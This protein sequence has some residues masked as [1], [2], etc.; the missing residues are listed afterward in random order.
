MVREPGAPFLPYRYVGAQARRIDGGWE[1]HRA[2]VE[3][4]SLLVNENDN[5]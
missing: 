2:L 5:R 3:G 4:R 1:S